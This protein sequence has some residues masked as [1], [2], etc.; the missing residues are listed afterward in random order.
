MF[1]ALTVNNA[2]E[3]VTAAEA[4]SYKDNFQAIHKQISHRTITLGLTSNCNLHDSIIISKGAV[5]C[6]KRSNAYG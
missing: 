3:S 1:L 2:Q 5:L 6:E 4:S